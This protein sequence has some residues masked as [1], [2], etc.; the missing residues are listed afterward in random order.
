VEIVTT[1]QKIALSI[2]VATF[3]LFLAWLFWP[4][5]EPLTVTGFEW[6]LTVNIEQ[7]NT[8]QEKR[9]HFPTG[10]RL[11]RT[12]T[13]LETTFDMDGNP[14][15]DTERY[16]L[17]EIERWQ[18]LESLVSQGATNKPEW[19]PYTLAQGK[20]PY[21]TGQQRVDSKHEHYTV[22][23]KDSQGKERTTTTNYTKWRALSKDEIVYATTTRWGTIWTI[24][25]L[26]SNSN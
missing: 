5:Y 12:W 2:T 11:I 6:K 15:F 3:V 7:L 23:L 21:N 22:H 25:T 4:Q 1:N 19:P 26:E 20:P 13:E 18:H 16:Y 9:T 24:A 8:V 10:A 17:Y 14:H